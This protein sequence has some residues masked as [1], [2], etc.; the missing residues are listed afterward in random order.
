LP[1]TG[2]SEDEEMVVV[3]RS[4]SVWRERERE[5]S[6]PELEAGLRVED[7]PVMLQKFL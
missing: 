2:L 7:A 6:T 4:E 3:A 1:A 5:I